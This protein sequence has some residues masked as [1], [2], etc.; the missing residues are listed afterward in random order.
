VARASIGV[1]VGVVLA[2][3]GCERPAG[4]GPSDAGAAGGA[5]ALD[6]RVS[7]FLE[8]E[9]GK[10]VDWNVP[11]GD[12]KILH[13]LVVSHGFKRILEIGTSTGHSGVWLGWAAAKTGGR[14]TT[15]EIDKGRRERA[16]A[17]FERAGVSG[18]VDSRLGDA[19]EL[20]RQLPGP[21]DFVFS[22]ADKGWYLRYFLDL[23]AKVAPG[24]CFTA[25]NVLH[26]MAPEVTE[27]L[28]RVRTHPQYTTYIERGETGEGISV[29]CK[30]KGTSTSTSTPRRP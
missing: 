3:A 18:Y 2:L 29:S 9:R 30:R 5:A 1:V 12:G 26:P 13:D 19:H 21:F 24:G 25:H 11:Y 8:A 10:W 20:V 6:R 7:G 15:L 28:A 17:S 4:A 22:D 14:V 16:L 27:F 23:D